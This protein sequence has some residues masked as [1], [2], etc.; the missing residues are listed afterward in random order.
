MC[1]QN[2]LTMTTTT[3]NQTIASNYTATIEKTSFFANFISW[4]DAQQFNRLL[5]LGIALV[6]HG[7]ILLPLT[8]AAVMFSGNSLALL[9]M[10][11]VAMVMTLVTNLAALPTK[12]TIPIFVLS[13]LIDLGIFIACSF[14]GFSTAGII[15]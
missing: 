9:V 11:L 12:I 14:N 7:S 13:I 1:Y 15:Q 3:L 5:W 2:E 8:G 4:C 6:G 10:A